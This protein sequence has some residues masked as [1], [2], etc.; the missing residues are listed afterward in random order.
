MASPRRRQ[1]CPTRQDTQNGAPKAPSRRPPN[2]CEAICAGIQSPIGTTQSLSIKKRK[3][4]LC[5]CHNLWNGRV[6]EIIW[7][8]PMHFY[9]RLR[10]FSGHCAFL[11]G[12]GSAEINWFFLLLTHLFND[13]G[14]STI[15]VLCIWDIRKK[16]DG[17]GLDWSN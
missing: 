12:L 17:L 5:F 8:P 2:S 10:I 7:K 13:W 1:H 3:V 16:R 11:V 15:G 14:L 9:L 4:F 6:K